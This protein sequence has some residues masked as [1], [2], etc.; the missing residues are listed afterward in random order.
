MASTNYSWPNGNAPEQPSSRQPTMLDTDPPEQRFSVWPTQNVYHQRPRRR[1]NVDPTAATVQRSLPAQRMKASGRAT[2]AWALW[3]FAAGLSAAPAISYY[4]D[5]VLEAGIAWTAGWAPA[6]LR[7][8]LP[9]PVLRPAPLAPHAGTRPMV[10]APVAAPSERP[11]AQGQHRP[12]TRGKTAAE[13]SGA[14]RTAGHK[15]VTVNEAA[16]ADGQAAVEPAAE[17]VTK[18]APESPP[19]PVATA[20]KSAATKSRESLDELMGGGAGAAKPGR[21][22]SREIDA[23]LKDVQKSEPAP[24]KHAPAEAAEALTAR[25]IAK[26]MSGVRANANTCGKR[27]GEHGTADLKLTVGKDGLVADVV[28]KGKLADSPIGQ[29][30]VQAARAATFSRNSGLTFDYRIDV[31]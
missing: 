10:V 31:Q 19:E 13:S 23:M 8:Y 24:V 28:L 12:A 9:K 27:F 18:P 30:I 2:V 5:Q 6:F 11:S 21:S 26:V 16:S 1:S 20:S 25:E 4:A 29:C 17:P 15:H 7:P 3:A 14:S 22:T